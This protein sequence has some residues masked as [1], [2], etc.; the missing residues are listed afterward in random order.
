MAR[1]GKYGDYTDYDLPRSTADMK[2]P[3]HEK[4]KGTVEWLVRFALGAHYL[5]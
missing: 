4:S 5:P 3:H 2:S 1:H